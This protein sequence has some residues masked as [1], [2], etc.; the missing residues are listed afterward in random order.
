MENMHKILRGCSRATQ[1]STSCNPPILTVT[2]AIKRS[3]SPFICMSWLKG[4]DYVRQCMCRRRVQQ[5]NRMRYVLHSPIIVMLWSDSIWFCANDSS[6]HISMASK[7]SRRG[8]KKRRC[9]QYHIKKGQHTP[10]TINIPWITRRYSARGE[11]RLAG[12]VLNASPLPWV[13]VDSHEL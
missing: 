3:P 7:D 13:L 2:I 1:V 12:V 8:R 9:S 5:C 11:T 4:G 6:G 10:M